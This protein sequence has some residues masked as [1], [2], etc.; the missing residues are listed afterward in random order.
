MIKIKVK[1]AITPDAGL[2]YMPEKTPK[3]FE[4]T[5]I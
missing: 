4:N 2:H 3:S 1:K 5:L